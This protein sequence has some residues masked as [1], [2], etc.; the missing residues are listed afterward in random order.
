MKVPEI[1]AI[2]AGLI[3]IFAALYKNSE[4]FVPE[5][6]DQSSVKRTAETKDS[7]YDQKTNHMIP[8]PGPSVPIDGTPS[9]FRVNA[10]N[11]HVF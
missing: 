11:A 5:F 9:P 1:L 6:L 10:Y 2:G 7:S 4:P 8:T 3:L